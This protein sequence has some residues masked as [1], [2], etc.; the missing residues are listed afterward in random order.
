MFLQQKVVPVIRVS[1]YRECSLFLQLYAI[2][3][4]VATSSV[5]GI[6]VIGIE[7]FDR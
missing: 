7:D 1:F 5:G 2:V 6:V 3:V 4:V